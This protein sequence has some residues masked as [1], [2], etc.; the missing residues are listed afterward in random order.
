MRDGRSTDVEKSGTPSGSLQDR[1]HL[2]AV[3][4]FT[5]DGD[6]LS[7]PRDEA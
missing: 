6:L 5:A 4:D 2:E 3:E 1:F 7:L